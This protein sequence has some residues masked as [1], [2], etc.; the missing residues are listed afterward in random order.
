MPHHGYGA[1]CCAHYQIGVCMFV[2]QVLIALLIE[3]IVRYSLRKMGVR[4]V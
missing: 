1:F 3:A 2:V 4:Y